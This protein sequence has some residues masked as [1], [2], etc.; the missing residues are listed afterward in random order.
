MIINCKNIKKLPYG[1]NLKLVAGENGTDRVIKWAHIM[2][3]PEYINW[4]KGGELIFIT[5]IIIKN[6]TK[7]LLNLIAD[8][9]SK[10]SAG[11]VINVG[12]HINKTPTEAIKL[13]NSLS[14]PIFELPFEIRLI[15]VTEN[16]CEAIFMEKLEQ[17][18]MN[19]FMKN[20]IS[21]DLN[22][23]EE[24]INRAMF[25]GYDPNK[26]YYSIVIFI[27]N[28]IKLIKHNDVWDENIEF[29]LKQNIQQIVIDIM[30]KHNKKIINVTE[31]KSILLMVPGEKLHRDNEINV[32]AEEIYD[33]IENKIDGIETSI[34][35][36]GMWKGIENLK[37]SVEEA[38]KAIKVLKIDK[39]KFC[40]YEDIGV[41]KLFFQINDK[42]IIEQFYTNILENL[43]DYDN[44]NSTKLVDTLEVY[45]DKNCNLIQAASELFIH[46]NTLKYRIKRIDD[47][48]KCDLR[49]MEVLLNL[50]MAF[51]AKKFLMCI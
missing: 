36:G 9:N 11:M 38:K 26:S 25:Y 12:P 18:S 4:L 22:Y 47:I 1:N 6:D 28:F 10:N 13:A 33:K 51:K 15:D 19:S 23:D 49:D 24:I 31:S 44:K 50:S 20:L 34:G 43:I 27:N 45:I 39:N 29:R 48:L 42:G 46:K 17:E 40:N 14:F 2:E 5:G 30:Y 35:I 32:I 7:T 8:L 21:G 41:Y 3:N 16:I 37:K